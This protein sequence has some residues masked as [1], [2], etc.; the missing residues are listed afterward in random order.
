MPFNSFPDSRVFGRGQRIASITTFNSFPDSSDGCGCL[1][2]DGL[3]ILS[4]PFRIPE[5]E[6][7]EQLRLLLSLSI[8]FRIPVGMT[9][10]VG[11]ARIMKHFQF[12]SGF[13]FR[14]MIQIEPIRLQPFNSFPDSR[15]N[16]ITGG[17]SHTFPFNSFPDSRRP[18]DR[19]T[20]PSLSTVT[21]NSFPDS[22]N[23]IENSERVMNFILSIPF[24]IPEHT[25]P[26]STQ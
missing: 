10:V 23:R 2:R 17:A 3:V 13:Q 26:L 24:R 12:L 18:N 15:E 5:E 7:I 4:I 6:E 1:N 9:L 20:L 16:G 22:S 19:A 14:H 25:S 21:F 8:P 11:Q